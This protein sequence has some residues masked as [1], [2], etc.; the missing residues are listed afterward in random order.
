MKSFVELIETRQY[1]AIYRLIG[2]VQK[3]VSALTVL[4][5]RIGVFD[6]L[7]NTAVFNELREA[8]WTI[9]EIEGIRHF[10]KQ[11]DRADQ[12]S[13]ITV[14]SLKIG[15]RLV[16]R[17][18]IRAS[19]KGFITNARLVQ[20][21]RQQKE[22][23]DLENENRWRKERGEQPSR[24]L[25]KVLSTACALTLVSPSRERRRRKA[26]SFRTQGVESICASV[27]PQAFLNTLLGIEIGP[28][29][30]RA[31][32]NDAPDSCRQFRRTGDA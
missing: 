8:S 27:V 3:K 20:A 5:K 25:K 10:A 24:L 21:E 23:I 31:A 26:A 16:T 7:G 9:E 13:D 17:A 18:E 15:D 14:S 28:T 12:L 1:D 6:Q 30:D 11:G 32:E 19:L 29:Y 22:A 4:E 2:E